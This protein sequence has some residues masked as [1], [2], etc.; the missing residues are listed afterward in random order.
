MQIIYE[1]VNQS[2]NQKFVDFDENIIDEK[3]VLPLLN[4]TIVKIEVMIADEN[5]Q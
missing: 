2:G 5:Q 4:S 3:F 1:D